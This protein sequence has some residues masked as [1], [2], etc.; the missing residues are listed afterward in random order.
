MRRIDRQGP[1]VGG[2]RRSSWPRCRTEV[3]G[4]VVQVGRLRLP[5][6]ALFDDRGRGGHVAR[7]D[8]DLAKPHVGVDDPGSRPM[9]ASR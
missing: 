1:A 4:Q 8:V 6:D 7:L 9:I 2:D 3:A 5:G